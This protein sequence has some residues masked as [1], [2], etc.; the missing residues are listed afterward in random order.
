MHYVSSIKT[1]A[2][3][4]CLTEILRE[5][6]KG[7][8]VGANVMELCEK[9]DKMILE[10]TSKV[11]KKEKEMRKGDL[12]CGWVV[13][14]TTSIGFPLLGP[15]GAAGLERCPQFRGGLSGCKH[16]EE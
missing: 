15:V 6:I 2:S 12:L 16:G 8:V 4:L 9:G 10:E 14:P 5:V 7:C 3:S 1:I 11:Y 13:F